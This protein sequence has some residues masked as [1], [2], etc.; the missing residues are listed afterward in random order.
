M[1]NSGG[2]LLVE[3]GQVDDAQC[4][5]VDHVGG[6]PPA[7][8][9]PTAATVRVHG[10]A[11]ANPIRELFVDLPSWPYGYW[12]P[13]GTTAGHLGALIAILRHEYGQLAFDANPAFA[14][15]EGAGD[16]IKQH[17][18]WPL[19]KPLWKEENGED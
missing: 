15:Q 2:F 11:T 3:S 12:I 5:T 1:S 18:L 4:Y 13:A 14:E 17:P 8:V 19:I 9:W 6:P 16:L 7:E 10:L